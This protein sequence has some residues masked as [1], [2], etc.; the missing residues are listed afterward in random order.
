MH[1]SFLLLVVLLVVLL[2]DQ[3]QAQGDPSKTHPATNTN[4]QTDRKVITGSS[5]PNPEAK[6]LYED[7]TK[8]LEMGQV[9]EAVERFQRALEIDPEYGEAYSALGRAFF[10]LRQ[11]ENAHV[12]L[13][14]AIALKAK[15]RERQDALQKKHPQ[16]VEP[17]PTPAPSPASKPSPTNRKK[18]ET[19]TPGSVSVRTEAGPRSSHPAAE[20]MREETR[21]TSES[22]ARAPELNRDAINASASRQAPV[23]VQIAMNV[24]PSSPM[25]VPAVR[26]NSS[27]DE[28]ALTNIY[29]VGPKDVLDIRISNSQPQQTRV[30][31]V[32]QS[33]LLE[34]P[35]LSEALSVAGLTVE[36]VR[37]RIEENL[38][39]RALIENPKVFVGV[40][41][42]ASH[43]IMVDGLVKI[44]GTKLL[45]SEAIPLAVVV[46]EAQ[47][48]LEATRVT[49]VRNGLNQILEANLSNAADMSFLVH[50]GDI[51]TLHSNVDEF[52]YI[53]GKVKSPGE[54]RYRLGLTLLQAIIAAGGSKSNSRVAEIVR[55]DGE[56]VRTRFDLE[57]IQSGKAADPLVKPRDRII[58]H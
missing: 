28:I 30:F 33:G 27:A 13:R 14:R 23:D 29:R 58:L 51:V 53:G 48:L 9:S 32:S 16:L 49:V 42:H 22:N 50:P 44:P 15:E 47:P 55:G 38:K 25:V 1:K 39:N 10:K 45:K 41:E 5:E 36:E 6:S 2:S 52:L 17:G 34:H 21:R 40:L 43:S 26:P 46:A 57:A 7:G 54:K 19:N 3:V 35:H 12:M 11:W 24:P 18:A 4:N 31:T 8:R 37:A 56:L 20:V